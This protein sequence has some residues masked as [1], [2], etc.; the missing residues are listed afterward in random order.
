MSPGVT[1]VEQGDGSVVN[2]FYI[3]QRR[4]LQ[5]ALM[6]AAASCNGRW[7]YGSKHGGYHFKYKLAGYLY[8]GDRR[9]SGK[10]A[11]LSWSYLAHD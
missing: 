5:E 2:V 7:F 9:V 1:Q 3:G 11:T 6:G 8:K 10:T 4:L